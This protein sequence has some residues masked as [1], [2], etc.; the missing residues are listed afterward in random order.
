LSFNISIYFLNQILLFS[1][2]HKNASHL[3]SLNI[4]KTTTYAER[5]LGLALGQAHAGGGVKWLMGFQP[6]IILITCLLT[7]FYT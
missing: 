7:F 6:S 3:K 5:N 2:Q 1:K 4:E